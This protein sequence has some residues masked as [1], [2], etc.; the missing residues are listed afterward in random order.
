MGCWNETCM[1]SHLQ[2]MHGDA[3]ELI[4]LVNNNRDANKSTRVYYNESY[5]PLILP[6]EA[7]YNDYGGVENEKVPSYTERLL[8][9][10][11]FENGDGTEYEYDNMQDFVDDINEGTGIYLKTMIGKSKLECVFVH[12]KLYDMLVNEMQNRVPYNQKK[13]LYD[14]YANL[15]KE[16]LDLWIEWRKTDDFEKQFKISSILS[17]KLFKT[18]AY[19]YS[20]PIAYLRDGITENDGDEFFKELNIYIM[21][22]YALSTGRYG[23]ITRCGAGGQDRDCSI[24]ATVAMFILQFRKRKDEDGDRIYCDEE[25]IFWYKN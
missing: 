2:I 6:I 13:T 17:D 12:A 20:F 10:M 19:G 24:Q 11:T 4:I 22:A 7:T 21:F 14:L 3:V 23:Y 15:N 8:R 1:L 16:I 9:S 25:E 18:C 5:A